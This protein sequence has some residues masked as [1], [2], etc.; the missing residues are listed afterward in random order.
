M[1][2]TI[3]S[4]QTSEIFQTEQKRVQIGLLIILLCAFILRLGAVLIIDMPKFGYSEN[5]TIAQNIF[6]GKGYTF[7]LYGYR[8]EHPFQSFMPPLYTGLILL[9]LRLFENSLLALGFI[10][11]MLSTLSL[12]LI[13]RLTLKISA[14]QFLALLTAIGLAFYPAFILSITRPQT[15]T[16]NMFLLALLLL[17]TVQLKEKPTFFW[18]TVTGLVLGIALH[19]RPMLILYLPILVLWLWLN[20]PGQR[21]RAIKLSLV[22]TAWVILLLMPWT[23]RNYN[24]HQQFVFMSTNGGFNFWTGNNAFTTGSGHEVYTEKAYAFL[25]QTP[26]KKQAPIVEMHR[27]PLPSHIREQI[28]TIDEVAFDQQLYQA[29]FAFMRDNP[30]A[31]A[32]LLWVK[33]KSFVWFRPNLGYR[34]D[35]TWTQYYKYLYAALLI[36]AGLGFFLSLSQWRVYSLLYLLLTYYTIFYTIFHVQ[37]RFRWE[38]EPYLFIFAALPIFYAL[39]RVTGQKDTSSIDGSLL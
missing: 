10:Q 21:F 6:Q 20:M 5:G 26:K 2:E 39:E 8:D 1:P 14:N 37:T 22:T 17:T 4:I 34:Y 35:A 30:R 24:I 19:S 12:Y 9:C 7:N 11:A 28:A 15:L 13:Y 18:A 33:L 31:W 38:I 3:K 32:D 29:G 25:D 27:Y 36:P 23:V 16:L